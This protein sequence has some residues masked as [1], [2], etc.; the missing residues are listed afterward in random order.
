MRY[1]VNI[2]LNIKGGDNSPEAIDKRAAEISGLLDGVSRGE[3]RYIG[4]DGAEVVE[5]VLVAWLDLPEGAA[6]AVFYALAEV[7][8][9]D[10]VAAWNE[11]IEVGLLIGP[12]A[13]EWGA[14]NPNYFIYC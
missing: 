14:F 5:P 8:G 4:P 7:M 1:Q 3:S 11:D 10:C 13:A 6:L 2:G 9:Q 12:K